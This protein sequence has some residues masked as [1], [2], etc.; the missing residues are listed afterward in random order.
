MIFFG[1]YIQRSLNLLPFP[2]RGEGVATRG[3]GV[4]TRGRGLDIV[5]DLRVDDQ[6]FK[7]NY[8]PIANNGLF[9][10]QKPLDLV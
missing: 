3:E 1:F 5:G 10:T 2:R 8:L 7:A 4:A 9:E 6:S